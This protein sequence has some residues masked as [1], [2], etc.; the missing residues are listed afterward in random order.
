VGKPTLLDEVDEMISMLR[1]VYP[2][3]F[4]SDPESEHACDAEEKGY[5]TDPS[6]LEKACQSCQAF[7]HATRAL[8]LYLEVE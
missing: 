8:D 6:T 4:T 1:E 2:C 7:F 5:L 3:Q